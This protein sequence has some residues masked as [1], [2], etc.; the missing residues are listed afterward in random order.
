MSLT[1]PSLLLRLRSSDNSDGWK[2]FATI[3]AQVLSDYARP[4]GRCEHDQKDIIQNVWLVLCR[5]MPKFDYEPTRGGFRHLLRRIVKTTAIDWFRR[6]GTM[7]L[8]NDA[9][10]LKTSPLEPESTLEDRRGVLQRALEIAR[11]KSSILAWSCFER[12]VLDRQTARDVGHHLGLS[13]NAVYVNASRVL[14]RVRTLCNE[15]ERV[16]E[17]E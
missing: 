12:H 14:D 5:I 4:Y 8:S 3:Y 11:R 13:S 1:R 16:G 9:V 15:I 10:S 17:N 2:E 7:G 6:R